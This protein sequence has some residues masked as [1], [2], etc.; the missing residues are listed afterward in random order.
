MPV[1]HR[2]QVQCLRMVRMLLENLRYLLNNRSKS[3]VFKQFPG[4]LQCLLQIPKIA[5]RDD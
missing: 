5:V 1:R 4:L 2:T 3:L